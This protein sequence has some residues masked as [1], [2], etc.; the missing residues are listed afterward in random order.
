MEFFSDKPELLGNTQTLLGVLVTLIVLCLFNDESNFLLKLIRN[1]TADYAKNL[2]EKMADIRI[3][4]QKQ[5]EDMEKEIGGIVSNRTFWV[6]LAKAKGDD[7][8]ERILN[9]NKEEQNVLGGMLDNLSEP[10]SKFGKTDGDLQ[11]KRENVFVSL[12]FLILLLG[13]M[14]I[15]ACCISNAVGSLFFRYLLLFLLI[16]HSRFGFASIWIKMTKKIIKVI[17]IT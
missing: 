6:R 14:M 15:D 3:Q 7:L 4:I 10:L 12:F 16:I 13:V 1:M 11:L 8:Y 17:L 9:N 2:Q 5:K